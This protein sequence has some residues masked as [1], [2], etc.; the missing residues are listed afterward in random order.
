MDDPLTRAAQQDIPVEETAE[1][2][3]TS[4]EYVGRW[5]RLVSTTNWEK[6]R[7]ISQWRMRLMEAGAPVQTY[8]D[9]AW[10]RRVG[11]VSP[12]HVG[13]LRRVYEQFGDVYDQYPGLYWTH[14]QV[15]L[16]WHDAEMWLEG[17]VQSGWSVTQMRT[18]RWEAMGAPAHQKPCEEDVFVA[19][20]DEDAGPPDGAKSRS[21]GL[22]PSVGVVQDPTGPA[23][24]DEGDGGQRLPEFPPPGNSGPAAEQLVAA[25][26][27]RPFQN[28]PDL[29]DDLAE[30]FEAFKLAILNHKLSGWRE[31]RCDDVLLVLDALKQLAVAPGEG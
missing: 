26:P 15:A 18:Q 13:R 24:D 4:A 25:D 22:N 12:Q 5:N 31:A 6:G 11:A 10:S 27:V 1:V 8:S 2:A 29:P 20:M 30:A 23:E 17:A 21:D 3:E 14:F 16:D 19:E 9:E 7:I 28:L